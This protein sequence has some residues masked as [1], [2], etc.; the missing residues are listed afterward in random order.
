MTRALLTTAAILALATPAIADTAASVSTDLNVRA[1]PNS[2]A[3]IVTTIPA[4]ADIVVEECLERRNWCLVNY[5]GQRGYSFA[6]YIVADLDGNRV[7][8]RENV[9][10]LGV[11]LG[12]VGAAVETVTDTASSVIRGTGDAIA[13][14]IDPRPDAVTYVRDNPVET[15]RL[16]GEVV[17]G[18]GL[19]RSVRTESIPDYEY[20]YAYVNGEAVLVDPGSRRV[21]YVIR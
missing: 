8:V 18:A 13:N 3:A 4:N 14:V 11:A 17:V 2:S 9:G 5:D 16:R 19:P 12:T 21:V 7:R 20:D 1:E 6:D 10:P 15:A